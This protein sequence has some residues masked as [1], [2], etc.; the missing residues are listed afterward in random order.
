MRGTL[1]N[2]GGLFFGIAAETYHEAPSTV[3]CS[4]GANEGPWP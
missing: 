2:W 4:F 1:K 3:E